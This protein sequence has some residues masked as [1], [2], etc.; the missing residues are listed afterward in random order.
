MG[1]L[2]GATGCAT[3]DVLIPSE[4]GLNKDRLANGWSCC[5]DDFAIDS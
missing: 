1:T 5:F 4:S 3:H 2:N